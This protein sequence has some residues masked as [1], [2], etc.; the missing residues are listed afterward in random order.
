VFEVLAFWAGG[1]TAVTLEI[2][3]EWEAGSPAYAVARLKPWRFG[4]FLAALVLCWPA[5]L[6]LKLQLQRR[7]QRE[8]EEEQVE[9]ERIEATRTTDGRTCF[10]WCPATRE[11]CE[12]E[13]VGAVCLTYED[14]LRR[15][16]SG[17]TV[18]CPKC[19]KENEVPDASSS[20][21]TR[22]HWFCSGCLHALEAYVEFDD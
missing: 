19:G 18:L 7:K 22:V 1:V 11:E 15:A 3:L 5:G 14:Q 4:L 6:L 20:L 8:E 9:W 16:R 12:R 13:C 2:W 21:V 10:A 17:K